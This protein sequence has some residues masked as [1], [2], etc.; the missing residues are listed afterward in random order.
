MRE[1]FRTTGQRSPLNF[2]FRAG[3]GE[4]IETVRMAKLLV[5]QGVKVLAGEPG[6]K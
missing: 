3:C 6:K 2:L 1:Q 4:F 5:E